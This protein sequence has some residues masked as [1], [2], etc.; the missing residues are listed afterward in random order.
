MK[1]LK[2]VPRSWMASYLDRVYHKPGLP[3]SA[4]NTLESDDADLIPMLFSMD[5]QMALSTPLPPAIHKDPVLAGRVFDMRSE[6]VG[7]RLKYLIEGLGITPQGARLHMG[8]CFKLLFGEGEKGNLVK[9][10]KHLPTGLVADIPEHTPITSGFDFENNHLDIESRVVLHPSRYFLHE[11]F[12]E[13]ASF[14]GMMS[15]AKRSNV[16][17]DLVKVSQD[18]DEKQS[19]A[20][21]RAKDLAVSSKTALATAAQAKSKARTEKARKAIE[22]KKNERQKRRRI[23]VGGLSDQKGGKNSGAS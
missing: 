21:Q 3:P 22:E 5:Q 15:S 10:V 14:K 7:R 8:G 6:L 13:A 2:L 20:Q 16:Y 18:Q 1:A 17:K 9:Q 11:F 4:L 19:V 23:N 12:D